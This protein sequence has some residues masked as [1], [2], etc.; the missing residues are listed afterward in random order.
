MNGYIV[1][2]F[3]RFLFGVIFRGLICSGGEDASI[4]SVAGAGAGAGAGADAD[5]LDFGRAFAGVSA[6]ADAGADRLDTERVPLVPGVSF[7]VD[8]VARVADEYKESIEK[9][10]MRRKE[11]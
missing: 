11:N 8:I 1:L 10:K 7:S 6:D 3:A 4:G 2:A 5:R 9:K